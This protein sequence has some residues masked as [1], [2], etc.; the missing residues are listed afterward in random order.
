M[1]YA[2]KIEDGLV[3]QVGVLAIDQDCP[4]GWVQSDVKVGIGFSYTGG[5]FRPAIEEVQVVDTGSTEPPNLTPRQW[6][7]LLDASGARDVLNTVLDAMPKGTPDEKFAWAQM[8][9]T[10]LNSGTYTWD[11]TIKLIAG[12]RSMGVQ[13]IP[14]DEE[15]RSYWDMAAADQG[16]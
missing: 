15:L 3:V 13:D 4:V 11:T 6:N 8:K 16:L 9:A 7:L 12:I 10:A 1:S 2:V 14:S 5:E